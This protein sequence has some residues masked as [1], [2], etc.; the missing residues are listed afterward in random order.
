MC[1]ILGF[2][3]K[4][5]QI[6]QS[7]FQKSLDMLE[8]RGPD[9]SGTL[10]TLDK[11]IALG[12]KRLS[13]IDLSKNAHQ[14]M[15]DLTKDISIIFNGEIYNF[16]EIREQLLN[17]EHIFKSQSDTEV[18]LN[19]Y[20]EWGPGILELL[21]GSFAI[22]IVDKKKDIL[23]LA[24][25]RG[26]EKPLFYS[27]S[28]EEIYFASELKPLIN[29]ST[30]SRKISPVSFQH[31]FSH[32]YVARD[33]SIFA[34]IK[35]LRPGHILTFDL[36]TRKSTITKYWNI[37]NKVL[38]RKKQKFTSEEDLVVRLEQLM[39][40]SIEGQLHADVPVSI[41]LSGGVDSSLITSLAS[42]SVEKLNT[43]TVKFSG[44]QGFD[45]AQHAAFIAKTFS[46]NHIELEASSINPTII[47]DIT[48]FID[49]PIFDHSVIPT[50]LLSQAISSSF[51]VALSGDGA[52]ELFGGYPHYNK[53]LGLKKLA[54]FFPL[55]A[56]KQVNSLSENLLPIGM[57]GRKTLE[58]FA[59]DFNNTYPNIS[60]FFNLHDQKNYLEYPFSKIDIKSS[61]QED[62]SQIHDY[63]SRATLADFQNYLTELLLVKVDRCSMAN[64][65]EIRAP[66]L[67]KDIIEFAFLEVP[68]FLKINQSDRKIILRK[69]AT[70]ILPKEFDIKR[71]QG[72]SI[73][74]GHFLLEKEW[75]DYFNQKILD[76]DP[77][78]FNQKNILELL[79]DKKRL[80]ANA[81]R[82]FGIVFFICW[83]E[84]FQPSF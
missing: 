35:K 65:L 10:F 69:L 15:S 61:D 66:F 25:D 58:F 27:L 51:K 33:E 47:D 60:E 83:K 76:S 34:D 62:L 24:R 82:L 4:S 39:S 68:S 21:T 46:T 71:K 74:L 37:V 53:L 22:A 16:Q 64:S 67:D 17:L 3:I 63:V 44:H 72:F 50:F 56:R 48:Y 78:I 1:G 54:R 30:I 45:E 7:E 18:I 42:R 8:H 73:P 29:F 79:N 2:A 11:K 55:S 80:N 59:S 84:R 38:Q 5:S 28:N 77:K 81:S 57:R 70:K 19:G 49:E 41:M 23:I 36:G 13:I 75:R 32:G 26:G 31:L 14:P 6:S 43:F 20:V 40:R 12:H 52:D 9:D